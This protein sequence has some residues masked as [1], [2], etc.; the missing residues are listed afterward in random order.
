MSIGTYLIKINFLITNRY[1]V[2][3][4]LDKAKEILT[5]T[6]TTLTSFLANLSEG[7][8]KTNEGEDTW[9]PHDIVGHLVDGEI[10]NWMVRIKIILDDSGSKHF[11][12]FDRV[13]YLNRSKEEKTSKILEEFS[14]LR[15]HNL[16]ELD[17]LKISTS[18]LSKTGI[19]PEFGEVT[20]KQL[21]STWATHDLG[22]IAQIA[23]VMA[24]QYK[25]E[26]GPWAGYLGILKR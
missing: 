12:P 25:A 24:K 20:L 4:E 1:S 26:V 11:E 19:H 14:Q 23:R 6:P 22:H 7:W 8:L 3:F 15:I 13:A 9:S 16:A 5:Q 18:D 21:I 17:A 2:N 10:S